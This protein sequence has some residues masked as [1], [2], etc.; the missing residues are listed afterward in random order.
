MGHLLLVLLSIGQL[1][2]TVGPTVMNANQWSY[3]DV[4]RAPGCVKID[5]V[6]DAKEWRTAGEITGFSDVFQPG[7]AV[8]HR[9]TARMMW[10]DR[11]LYV[12]FDCEDDDI[13]GTYTKHDDP[14]YVEEAVEV[15]IDPEGKGRHYWEIDVSPRNV[16]VDLMIPGPSWVGLA[17]R[18]NKYDVKGLVTATKIY[19]TLNL[20]SDA[21]KGW[22]VEMA[23][24]WS[25]FKGR[26][27]NVPPID[28]ESWRANLFRIDILNDD[29][30][31]DQFV[32]WSKSPGVFH[33]PKNFGVIVFRR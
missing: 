23:I 1:V 18:N 7:R 26:K 16:V 12:S 17:A 28:R 24:P 21:D 11:Y 15:F 19:G 6:V 10:D 13:R 22:S 2:K 4:V 25:D 20:S 30:R 27:V 9:T 14:V 3:Y 8:K 32:S 29:R 33:Q 31:E 5:G